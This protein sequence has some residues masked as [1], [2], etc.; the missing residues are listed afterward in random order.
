MSS[1]SVSDVN[2]PNAAAQHSYCGTVI[3]ED[4]DDE[5]A[6]DSAIDALM[7]DSILN[8]E[9]RLLQK[10][11]IRN[12]MGRNRIKRIEDLKA[13]MRNKI[14]SEPLSDITKS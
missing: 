3:Y 13:D 10:M 11:I 2:K 5:I 12:F 9:E 7:K 6:H 4:D 14:E 1:S 8:E